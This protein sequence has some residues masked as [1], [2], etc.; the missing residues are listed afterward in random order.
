[1]CSTIVVFFF[2]GGEGCVQCTKKDGK[3]VHC[4]VHLIP[5]F[6]R[7]KHTMNTVLLTWYIV[8]R[9]YELIQIFRLMFMIN[10]N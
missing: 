4:T 6:F 5:S 9:F 8:C 2:G 3:D 7:L 1:M 10:Y